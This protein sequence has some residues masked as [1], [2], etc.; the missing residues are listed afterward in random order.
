MS[1]NISIRSSIS[2]STL[3]VLHVIVAEITMILA[4][5]VAYNNEFYRDQLSYKYLQLM[6]QI[7]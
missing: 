4:E 3:V 2:G 1:T 5:V 6:S 7:N